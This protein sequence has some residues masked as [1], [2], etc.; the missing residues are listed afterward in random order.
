MKWHEALTEAM[1]FALLRHGWSDVRI[2]VLT[3]AI[4]AKTEWISTKKHEGYRHGRA[5]CAGYYRTLE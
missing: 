1:P 5:I 4:F 3:M 2:R